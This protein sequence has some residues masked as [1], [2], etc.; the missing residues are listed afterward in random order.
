MKLLSS[1]VMVA[2]VLA[3]GCIGPGRPPHAYF[4]PIAEEY[5]V[6]GKCGSLH[7]GI[8]GKGPLERFDTAK[9]PRCWHRWRQISKHEFQRV[10]AE[11]FPGEWE[12]AS[13]YVKR[14]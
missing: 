7:G 4:P 2:A 1:V 12:K 13:P 9:A 6:C 5:Y 11:Q 14:P 3:S 8:Y 10:A